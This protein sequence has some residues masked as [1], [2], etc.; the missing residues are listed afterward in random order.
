MYQIRTMRIVPVLA[1]FA[2]ISSG[3]I[4]DDDRGMG[5]AV[6][7]ARLEGQLW[8]S[9]ALN[10]H[11]NPFDLEVDV[12]RGTA[13][14]SG[15]VEESVQ[16]DLAEEIA[17]SI[18]GINRVD[19]QIEVVR[20]R[21]VRR[22]SSAE[23]DFGTR[24]SDATT[25][26]TVKSKLLWNR[27]TEGLAINVSTENSVVTLEGQV[28][29][30]ASKQLAE[31]L[32]ANTEGVQQVRNR[33]DVAADAPRADRD[34]ETGMAISDA[35]IT[36][37]VKSTLLF[38]RNVSGTDISVETHDGVVTLEGR[39]ASDAEKALAVELA[40]DIRGVQRVDDRALRV[41]SL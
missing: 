1:L 17:L 14:V 21:D 40:R 32:A 6:N 7:D 4:A 41:A 33:L 8:M 22:E 37:K 27:N 12:S 38:S 29:S 25:T 2:L 23:R 15:K 28:D 35:W 36:S 19:N 26:A 24:I 18:N 34:R 39:V 16:R 11:L 31:R 10:R 5:E 20:D 3:A 30:D 9:Y 13:T